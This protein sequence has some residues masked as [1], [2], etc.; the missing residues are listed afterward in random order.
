MLVFVIPVKHPARSQSYER[1]CDLLRQ[2]LRS[3]GAQTDQHFATIVV[4]NQ[5]PPWGEDTANLAFVEVDFPPA[6]PPANAKDWV[7]WLYLDRGAKIAVALRNA[8]R[9]DPTHVMPVDADDFVSNR[10]ARFVR[11]HPDAP[12]WYMPTGLI[13]SGLFRIGEPREKFWSYCGTSHIFRRDMLPVPADLPLR[14]SRDE[15]IETLGQPYTERI[16]GNHVYYLRHFE[17][18]GVPLAPLPFIGGVWHADT[19]ENSSRAWWRQTRFGPI[20]GR[21]LEPEQVAEFGIPAGTRRATDTMLLY[22]WRA[23]STVAR[24]AKRLVGATRALAAA[25]AQV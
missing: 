23:R 19:G 5:R 21:A 20:W 18:R 15:V 16:L 6:E 4:C 3:V 7:N 10:L 9:F 17:E 14:P 12:G 13:W 2:T 1:V 25:R 22:G 11:E 24:A 8:E